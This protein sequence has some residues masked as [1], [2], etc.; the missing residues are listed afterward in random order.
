MFICI[1]ITIFCHTHPE[2]LGPFTEKHCFFCERSEVF[3]MLSYCVINGCFLSFKYYKIQELP[4]ASPPR[5]P[6]PRLFWYSKTKA[7]YATEREKNIPVYKNIKKAYIR[8]VKQFPNSI[9]SIKP[10]PF[11]SCFSIS[12]DVD[13]NNWCNVWWKTMKIKLSKYYFIIHKS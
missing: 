3:R 6:A 10:S 5:P 12:K 9:F 1:G 4:G 11:H 8:E 7:S 13:R 2:H